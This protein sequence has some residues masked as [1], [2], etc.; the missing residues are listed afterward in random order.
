[1]LKSLRL[2]FD[3]DASRLRQEALA[4]AGPYWKL[5]YNKANYEGGWSAL[6]SIR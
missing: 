4:L 6:P 1:M 5:H 3:C 2:P